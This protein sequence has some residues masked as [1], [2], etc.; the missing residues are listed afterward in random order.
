MEGDLV[1]LVAQSYYGHITEDAIASKETM[2]A[3]TRETII[4]G[5]LLRLDSRHHVRCNAPK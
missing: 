1:S 2:E 4:L 5:L 3:R